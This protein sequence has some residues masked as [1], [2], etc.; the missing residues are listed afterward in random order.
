[1]SEQVGVKYFL[2]YS[3]ILIIHILFLILNIYEFKDNGENSEK[4]I[5]LIKEIDYKNTELALQN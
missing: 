1:M 4:K 3:F 5:S 2:V